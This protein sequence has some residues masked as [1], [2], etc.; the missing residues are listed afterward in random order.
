MSIVLSF[1]G[2]LIFDSSPLRGTD[3]KSD[4][5]L[6]RTREKGG[7]RGLARAIL[8]RQFYLAAAAGGMGEEKQSKNHVPCFPGE[9]AFFLLPRKLSTCLLAAAPGIVGRYERK[10]S[11]AAIK[12]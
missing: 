8:F 4:T 6:Q 1:F 5:V 12:R 10:L 2:K 11:G 9:I 3:G 7:G